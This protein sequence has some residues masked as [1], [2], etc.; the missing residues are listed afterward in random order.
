LSPT[1][2]RLKRTR[3][4]RSTTACTEFPCCKKKRPPTWNL[5]FCEETIKNYLFAS[6]NPQRWKPL[7]IAKVA[8]TVAFNFCLMNKFINTYY[9]VYVYLNCVPIFCYFPIQAILYSTRKIWHYFFVKKWP[10][11]STSYYLTKI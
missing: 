9:I 10:L 1:F 6:E 8:L 4:A 11:F 2:Y 5:F 3:A 7:S